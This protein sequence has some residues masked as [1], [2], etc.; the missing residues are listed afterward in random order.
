MHTS[1]NVVYDLKLLGRKLRCM[2]KC[3]FPNTVN[4][5]Q[6]HYNNIPQYSWSEATVSL[7]VNEFSSMGSNAINKYRMST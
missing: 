3:S 2:C 7:M 5:D 4:A 6:S 1:A